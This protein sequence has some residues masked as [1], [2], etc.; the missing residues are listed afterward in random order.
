MWSFLNISALRCVECSI[1]TMFYHVPGER[2]IM[3]ML[4]NFQSEYIP[5][6]SFCSQRILALLIHS[7]PWYS[8]Q[9]WIVLACISGIR[10][11]LNRIAGPPWLDSEAPASHA[12]TSESPVCERHSHG[13]KD[14]AQGN[15]S[16]PNAEWCRTN[17]M[18]FLDETTLLAGALN[19]ALTKL[20][21][22]L[23]L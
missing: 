1:I 17:S 18:Q 14:W 12:F 5:G 11:K 16:N 6:Q 3:P 4:L 22:Y 19:D 2:D 15:K 9:R 8:S 7:S 23:D 20:K 21:S 10:M 13:L